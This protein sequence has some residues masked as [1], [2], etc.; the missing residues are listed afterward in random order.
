M[1]DTILSGYEEI[2]HVLA[3][4]TVHTLE[5]I[6]ITIVIYYIAYRSMCG[7]RYHSNK[8]LKEENM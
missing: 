2:L 5:I 8:H 3:K 1:I 7:I 4:V 6:G